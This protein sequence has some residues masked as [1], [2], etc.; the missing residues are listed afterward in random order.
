MRTSVQHERINITIETECSIGLQKK[1]HSQG[2]S[3]GIYT[4]NHILII[5]HNAESIR[6][7]K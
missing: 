6:M 1:R 3:K 4:S 7:E 2:S 5:L